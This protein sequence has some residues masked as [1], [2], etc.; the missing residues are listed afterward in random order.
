[1]STAGTVAAPPSAKES[2][3]SLGA[4]VSA[5]EF[6]TRPDRHS[7][8][9]P[10]IT[11]RAYVCGALFPSVESLAAALRALRGAGRTEDVVGLLIPLEGD[12]P[13]EGIVR[14]RRD[15]A[16][17]RGFN[18]IEFLMTALDPHRPSGWQGGW[19]PG[20]NAGA[21]VELLGD[22]TRWLVGIQAVRIHGTPSGA[23][24]WVMGR[25]NHA[26]AIHKVEGDSQ[27]GYVGMLA[28]YAIV[29]SL[30]PYV[31][32][33]LAAGDCVLTTCESD[34]NRAQNDER[35][36]KKAGA[37]QLFDRLPLDWRYGDR[38]A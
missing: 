3:A 27:E 18:L 26:A 30:A 38:Q 24:L 36:M 19:A 15:V 34:L 6:I 10:V 33:R 22:L 28:T 25:P 29:E 16:P 14:T 23:P 8:D 12:D 9:A 2:T 1:M 7:A 20:T 5:A 11:S 17:A 13:D 31:A 21:A 4:A 37:V 35:M 32:E